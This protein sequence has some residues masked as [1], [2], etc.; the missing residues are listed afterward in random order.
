MRTIRTLVA[1]IA[2]VAA[3]C[4]HARVPAPSGVEQSTAARTTGSVHEDVFF[5]TALGVRKH[6]AIYLPPSYATEST[7][8]FPVAYY[9]H[10]LGGTETD[11]LAK[12]NIDA[13]ADSLIAS[14]TP[15]LIIVM[16]DG[17][18]GWYSNWVDEV[19]FR[20]CADT[21]HGESADRYCVAYERYED[22]IARDVVQFI[23][24]HYRTR[25]TRDSRGIGGLS[26]GGYGAIELSLSHPDIF[27]AAASHSGV[28][29]PTYTGPHPFV[30]PARFAATVDEIRPSAGGFWP[31][32][33]HYWGTNIERWRAVDPARTAE[34]AQRSGQHVPALYFDCGKDD[35]FVD[36][37]RAL[38]SELNRLG[39]S[40]VY[41]E[42]PGAHTW[43]YWST[44]VSESL[45]WM[46]RQLR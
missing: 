20:T 24:A 39:V 7:R 2:L 13:T 35:P 26:M 1:S 9:L 6:L 46:A 25:A 21:L 42:S 43:S 37:N 38:D 10:G 29:A 45:A 4:A 5:S 22:Y 8:R 40:H 30:A 34:R 44:H 27:G 17:D 36:Q 14:G 12:G 33:L 19:S 23:D 28:L 31:R 16:P 15:E 3:G 41:R 18:D 11:W 32:Y